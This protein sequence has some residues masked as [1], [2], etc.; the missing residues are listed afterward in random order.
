M[1]FG[2]VRLLGGALIFELWRERGKYSIRTTYTVQSLDQMHDGIP[3]TAKTPPLRAGLRIA[4]CDGTA[5]SGCT[6]ST[7]EKVVDRAIDRSAA[8]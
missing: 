6:W 5:E 1:T 2:L 4:G 7:F 3:L 8:R